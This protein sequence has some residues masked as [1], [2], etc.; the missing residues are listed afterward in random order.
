MNPLREVARRLL[1]MQSVVDARP[2]QSVP[3]L[4]APFLPSA[5]SSHISILFHTHPHHESCLVIGK[6]LSSFF[7]YHHPLDEKLYSL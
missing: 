3:L 5:P 1:V 4:A 7:G 6:S 2:F